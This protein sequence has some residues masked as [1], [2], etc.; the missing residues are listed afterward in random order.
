MSTNVKRRIKRSIRDVEKYFIG[1]PLKTKWLFILR[2]MFKPFNP[3]IPRQLWIGVTHRCQCNCVH[4]CL[5]PLLNKGNDELRLEEINRLLM[6]AKELGF[7]EISYFGGEPLLRKDI[8]ELVRLS[9]SKGLMTGIYTNGILL[10]ENMTDELKKAGLA[11]CNVSLDSATPEI[12]NQL[13]AY[14]GSFEKAVNGVKFMVER[15]IK[16]SIWTYASKESLKDKEMKGLN[17]LIS[18]GR[19][20]GVWR[21][22]V[23]FPMASGNWLCGVEN[24]LTEEERQR[25]RTLSNAPFVVMEFPRENDPCLAGKKMI[26]VTPQG[27][28]SPC[29]TI[30]SFMGNIRKE[31]FSSIL[32]R[33]NQDFVGSH[34]EGCGECIMN[35]NQFREQIGIGGIN[36]NKVIS[37]GNKK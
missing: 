31:S 3:G 30:P 27:D 17:D 16:C 13:R 29:P 14:K 28:V 11:F 37:G 10:T 1:A 8:V 7:M 19:Q 6:S 9:S 36:N 22:V 15:G 24:I 2:S 18:L 5:G 33:V 21:V 4:C 20:L 32:R 25:V 26:Y 12:H 23:L 35:D 34:T